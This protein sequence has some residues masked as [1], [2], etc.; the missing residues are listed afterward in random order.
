[1]PIEY[2]QSELSSP[3]V[4]QAASQQTRQVVVNGKT[5]KRSSNAAQIQIVLK[6]RDQKISSTISTNEAALMLLAEYDCGLSGEP[7]NFTLTDDD[8]ETIDNENIMDDELYNF[9]KP[10]QMSPDQSFTDV[11]DPFY[12]LDDELPDKYQ[13][14]EASV[15]AAKMPSFVK[16]ASAIRS[17]R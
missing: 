4:S 6:A 16:I 10:E 3:A 15:K 11:N 14:Q 5:Y 1:M 2:T 7:S 17:G 12:Q 9:A 13:V 8:T